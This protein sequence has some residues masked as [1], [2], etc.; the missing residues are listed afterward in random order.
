MFFMSTGEVISFLTILGFMISRHRSRSVASES[1]ASS[2]S[3]PPIPIPP[4]IL[5]RKM[6]LRIGLY[7]MVS[8]FLNITGAV[9][10][11]HTVLDTT[12]TEVNWRL[13]IVDL[14][15]YDLRPLMYA[16]LAATDP[17]FLRAIHALRHPNSD[18]GD[19]T[20]VHVS[21]QER[22]TTALSSGSTSTGF[23]SYSQNC[24]TATELNGSKTRRG[25]REHIRGL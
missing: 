8:C 9:L 13:G 1:T 24:D 7:P 3:Q 14:L 11:I 17:S 21:L 2:L 4:I 5:Y 19:G 20:P 23:L 12:Y 6:I 25:R 22:N 16:T 15:I 10:D 18:P